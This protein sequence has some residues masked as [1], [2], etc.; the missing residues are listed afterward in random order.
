MTSFRSYVAGCRFAGLR[1]FLNHAAQQ[2][3]VQL[4]IEDE[5]KRWLNVKIFYRVEGTDANIQ[6][7]IDGVRTSIEAYNKRN[8]ERRAAI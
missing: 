8:R 7:F 3:D 6:R 1:A 5:I 2:T 4:T